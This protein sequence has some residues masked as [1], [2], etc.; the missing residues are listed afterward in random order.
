M[1]FQ[2]RASGRSRERVRLQVHSPAPPVLLRQPEVAECDERLDLG[3]GLQRLQIEAPGDVG[4][5][6]AVAPG[7][8][9]CAD[10]VQFPE[11]A[12][13]AAVEQAFPAV[14]DQQSPGAP[15]RHRRDEMA[16]VAGET[17]RRVA[18]G[19]EVAV[20]HQ[21]V[22]DD[23]AAHGDLAT[24]D[25]PDRLALRRDLRSPAAPGAGTGRQRFIQGLG[26]VALQAQ[27]ALEAYLHQYAD[28]DPRQTGAEPQP[29]AGQCAAHCKA[30]AQ[31]PEAGRLLQAKRHPGAPAVRRPLHAQQR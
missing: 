22:A 23:R 14:E 16:A 6:G 12:H 4:G 3:G 27:A 8:L 7:H 19:Y 24:V 18:A 1:A 26:T 30:T 5:N 13:G 17:R 28:D 20:G 29:E 11:I 25:H 21:V 2:V 31:A 10:A 9:G 15:A